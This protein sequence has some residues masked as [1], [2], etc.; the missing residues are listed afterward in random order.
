MQSE[1][2][3]LEYVRSP[4]FRTCLADSASTVMLADSIGARVQ[5]YFTRMDM[6]PTREI[7]KRNEDGTLEAT[8]G[9]T[10]ETTL[11]KTMEFAVDIRPDIAFNLAVSLLRAVQN[12]S[13]NLKQQYHIPNTPPL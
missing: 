7:V 3:T 9:V 8:R 12:L 13:D 10:P 4:E 5:I 2:I 1:S 11:Q 6:V